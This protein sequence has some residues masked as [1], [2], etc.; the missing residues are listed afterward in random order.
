MLGFRQNSVFVD[1]GPF[2]QF[3]GISFKGGIIKRIIANSV[4]MSL[5][6]KAVIFFLGLIVG[7]ILMYFLLILERFA[8]MYLSYIIP[9]FIIITVFF[10]IALVRR[11]INAD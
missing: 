1:L 9:F 3:Y 11:G 8:P 4:G 10:L 2:A 7:V 5:V 6:D